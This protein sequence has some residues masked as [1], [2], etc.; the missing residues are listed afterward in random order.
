[1]NARELEAKRI[2]DMRL[3]DLGLAVPEEHR[4]RVVVG[5][6]FGLAANLRD[7]GFDGFSK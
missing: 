6:A 5:E 1:M 2:D 7:V 3:L 4:L